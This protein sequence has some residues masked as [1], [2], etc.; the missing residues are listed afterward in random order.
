[1]TRFSAVELVRT[2]HGEVESGDLGGSS[3][4]KPSSR[5]RAAVASDVGSPVTEMPRAASAS[6]KQAT[7][8]SGAEAQHHAGLD[9]RRRGALACR[10]LQ[11]EVGHVF[12]HPSSTSVGSSPRPS[13]D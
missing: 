2:V 7:G 8:R 4:R 3:T 11:A 5:A 1:L 12:R 6:R 9:E 13:S 10:L